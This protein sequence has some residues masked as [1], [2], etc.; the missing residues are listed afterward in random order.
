MAKSI[1][2]IITI[3]MANIT[4]TRGKPALDLINNILN[5]CIN[6]PLNNIDGI[7]PVITKFDPRQHKDFDIDVMK[8]DMDNSINENFEQ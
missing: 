6:D 5:L 8:E 3:S 4:E 1:K 2:F 7:I